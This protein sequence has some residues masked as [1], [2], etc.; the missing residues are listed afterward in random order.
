MGKTIAGFIPEV[1]SGLL[2]RRINTNLVFRGVVNTDYE[3]EISAGGDTVRINEYGP[4]TIND[5]TSTSTGD[6]TIQQ[7]TDAQKILKIDQEKTFGYWLDAVDEAQIK[8][9]DM[10]ENQKN[11]AWAMGNNIDEYI[12]NL[13]TEAGIVAAGSRSGST[14]TGVNTSSTN[15]L[16]YMSIAAQKAA[17]ADMPGPWWMVVPPWFAQKLTLAKIVQDT[18]NSGTLGSGYVG[19]SIYGF[20]IYQSNN[21]VNGTPAADDACIMFGYRGS[22]SLAVQVLMTATA[23]PSKMFKTLSKGLVVYGAKVVRP[24]QLGVMYLDYTDEAS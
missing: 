13:Y 24:N 2:L 9:K 14:I 17:E 18:S 4:I 6:L 12:A 16:K 20:R 22:I 11:A 7:L 21:V 23:Q 10:S 15:V 5:Y 3:G 19:E 1:W 8:P